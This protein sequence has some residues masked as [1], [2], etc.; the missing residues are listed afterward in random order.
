MK[1][2]LMPWDELYPYCT[3]E[4]QTELGS[5]HS[6]DDDL[7]EVPDTDVERWL[8]VIAEFHAVQKEMFAVA[9]PAMTP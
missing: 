3:L 1:G 5:D 6:V 4:T 9:E 8:R 2:Y 7:R